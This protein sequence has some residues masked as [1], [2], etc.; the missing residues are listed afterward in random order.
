MDSSYQ[1]GNKMAYE[2]TWSHYSALLWTMMYDDECV[3]HVYIGPVVITKGRY[4]LRNIFCGTSEKGDKSHM[5]ITFIQH[6]L[7]IVILIKDWFSFMIDWSV[8]KNRFFDP[9]MYDR[10]FYFLMIDFSISFL[11]VFT[12]HVRTNLKI[13]TLRSK[14]WE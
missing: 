13:W 7:K 3:L 11:Q 12:I 6:S 2:H 9:I 5:S 1:K 8:F 10:S 4:R 14:P